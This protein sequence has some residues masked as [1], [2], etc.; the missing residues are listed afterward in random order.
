MT[1]PGHP[2]GSDDDRLNDPKAVDAA[3]D[4]IVA[5]ID[6][7]RTDGSADPWPDAEGDGPGN[8]GDPESPPRTDPRTPRADWSGWEDA[9]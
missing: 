1:A 6:Q 3:F 2:G 9:S 5:N 8:P 4:A 7:T